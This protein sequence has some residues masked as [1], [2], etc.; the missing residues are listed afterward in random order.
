MIIIKKRVLT[1]RISLHAEMNLGEKTN[2]V[3]SDAVEEVV[4][5]AYVT[6]YVLI[7]H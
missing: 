2:P 1:R 3:E 5:T 6:R 4:S 7:F